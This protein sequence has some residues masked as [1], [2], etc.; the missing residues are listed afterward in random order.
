MVK[1]SKFDAADYLDSPE[2]IAAYLIEAYASDDD[3]FLSDAVATVSRATGVDLRPIRTDE[4]HRAALKQ[5]DGLWSAAPETP[6][7]KKMSLIVALVQGYESK[8]WPT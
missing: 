2:M 7:A 1:T 4:E 5:I 6:E 8:R 3:A